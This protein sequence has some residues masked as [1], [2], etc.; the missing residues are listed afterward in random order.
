MGLL[1]KIRDRA[2]GKA[3]S[4]RPDLA[5]RVHIF[6]SGGNGEAFPDMD[7]FVGWATVYE[8]YVWLRK[9]LRFIADSIKFLPLMVVD[10]DG[11]EQS[12]HYITELF[13]YV[14]DTDNPVS[15]WE[16]YVIYK[17]LG[18]EFPLELVPDKRGVPVEVWARR[19]DRVLVVPD[20]APERK[21][22][23][24][25]AGYRYEDDKDY[26]I[27][28]ELM[29]FDKFA[30]PQ[31][32]W[33]GLNVISAARE[34]LGIDVFAH[35]S[36]K[37][38]LQKGSQPPYAIVAPTGITQT[39]MDRIEQRAQHKLGG[40]ENVYRPI[41]L[42]QGITDVKTLS[43]PERE[44][45]WME[46]SRFGRDEIGA[47]IGL[48]DLLMGYGSEQYDNSD[49]MMAHL[50]YYW[51]MTGGPLVKSRD[52][53]MTTFFHRH[54]PGLLNEKHRIVTDLSGVAV[55]REDFG[56]KLDQS[57]KLFSMGVPFE[58]INERLELGIDYAPPVMVDNAEKSAELERFRRWARK[59][60]KT[61][62]TVNVSEFASDT[63]NDAAKQ[64]ELN[65][66]MKAAR[67]IPEGAN[68]PLPALPDTVVPS[69]SDIQRAIDA[70]D[71]T[72]RGYA[73]I[74]D[75]QSNLS[76]EEL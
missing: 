10:A 40:Y 23:P 36:I 9:G 70:W 52:V 34:G 49:K 17:Y 5:G 7:S 73:G 50:L 6:S 65:D 35:R 72:M 66:M 26:L 67:I 19:P 56:D 3:I 4:H 13:E 47:I 61:G 21:L 51:T 33:R 75:A 37:N 25:I 62:K 30:H 59:R 14:N 44:L 18:G 55:L 45:R 76:G 20:I 71:S 12:G 1:R 60:M 54:Y 2:N 53:S 15:L 46:Q 41:M 11:Q 28:P 16:H 22:Y 39:E 58:K 32:P 69:D 27:P 64:A 43:Y 63:L 29:W 42:E 57:L 68:D 8:S 31:N 74:L 48:P 24:R 38:F